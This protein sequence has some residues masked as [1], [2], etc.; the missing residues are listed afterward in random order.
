MALDADPVIS[1][2][3]QG[4]HLKPYHAP[5]LPAEFHADQVDRLASGAGRVGIAPVLDLLQGA[6]LGL[7]LDDLELEQIDLA[8]EA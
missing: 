3:F 7:Q 8:V 5:L 4:L 1:W 2:R 6:A